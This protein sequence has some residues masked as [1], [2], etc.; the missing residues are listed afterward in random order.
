MRRANLRNTDLRESNLVGADLRETNLQDTNLTGARYDS[1][2][3]W[4]A[5]FDPLSSGA[6]ARPAAARPEVMRDPVP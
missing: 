2:T 6:L 5:G 4:P 1:N 3:R